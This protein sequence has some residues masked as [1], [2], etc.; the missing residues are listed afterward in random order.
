MVKVLTIDDEMIFRENITAFLEDSNYHVLESENGE[1]GLEIFRREKPDIVLCDLRMPK[2]DG[3]QVLAAVTREAPETPIIM[4]SGTGDIQD[5]IEALRLGA[6]DYILKPIQDMGTLEHAVNKALERAALL[7]EN[8]QHREHLQDEVEKR[9]QEILERT[10][11]LQTANIQLNNE[12]NERKAMEI[13]LKSSLKSLEKTIEGTIS[14]ISLIVERRDPYTG[15]HQRH[16]ARLTRAIAGEM[17]YPDEQIKGL[18]F[19][20]LI[21]DIGKLAVPIEILVK[22]GPIS[23][24]ETQII[25]THPDAGWEFLNKIEFPWPIAEIALQHHERMDGSGYPN[26]L[27]G[28]DI[29]PESRIV[30]VADV[31]E[32][33]M[34]HRPYRASL[35]LES[36]LAEITANRGRLYDADVVDICIKLFRQK[37]FTFLPGAEKNNPAAQQ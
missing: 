19:A 32:S 9:T 8:R 7:K 15:G 2:M 12:I 1:H 36:A 25:R 18:Y 16:V 24:L 3:F 14:T 21:H 10:R 6:W 35:G 29:L 5:V 11:D 27:S 30:A 20:G 34:F 22:P 33:M 4:I 26:G 28:K 13:R 31:L 23:R 37:N 17:G